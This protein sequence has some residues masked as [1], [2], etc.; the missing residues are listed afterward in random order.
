MRPEYV[1]RYPHAF[2][3]GQRQPIGI[4]RAPALNPRLVVADGP[5]SA[6]DVS[7][8][9]QILNLLLELHVNSRVLEASHLR[10]DEA[11]GV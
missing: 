6:L 9:A 1:R 10:P 4:A 2:S 8:Q 3:G 7:V 5:V 11:T